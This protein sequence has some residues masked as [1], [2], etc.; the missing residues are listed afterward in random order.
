[1]RAHLRGVARWCAALLAAVMAPSSARAC[2]CIEPRTTAAAYRSAALV[3]AGKVVDVVPRPEVQGF[4]YR[5][6]VSR[7]WKADAAREISVSTGTD[8]SF[9]AE[10]G[11][12]YLLFLLPEAGSGMTTGRCMGNG[13]LESKRGALGWLDRRGRRGRVMPAR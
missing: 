4:T 2:R 8:C 9:E 10:R 12:E 13:V 1:M 3:V 7:A 11:R 5:V 6:R